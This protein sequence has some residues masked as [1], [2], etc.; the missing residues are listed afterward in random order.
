[1]LFQPA[2]AETY[3]VRVAG[4]VPYEAD[5]TG[6]TNLYVDPLSGWPWANVGGDWLD[7]NQAQQGSTPWA[8][9]AVNS[10]ALTGNGSTYRYTGVVITA[11]AQFVQTSGKPFALRI[12]TPAAPRKVAGIATPGQ[13]PPQVNVTYGDGTSAVLPCRVVADT[14]GTGLTPQTFLPS[15]ATPVF[16]EFDR[17]TKAVASATLDITFNAHFTAAATAQIMLLSPAGAVSPYTGGAGLAASGGELD[18]G[19]SAVSGILGQHRYQDGS[20]L[21]DWV[22]PGAQTITGEA[23]YDPALWGGAS[24]TSKLPHAGL[25]KWINPP[26]DAGAIELVSSSYTGQGF[27]PVAP[28]LGAIKLRMP[29]L[30]TTDGGTYPA[31]SGAAANMM[32]FLPEP[33]FGVLPEIYVRFY[34]RLGT[35]YAITPTDRR[36][37]TAGGSVKWADMSGKWGI[38]AG[39]TT[40]YGGVSGTSG[41]GFGH[42]NR[43]GWYDVDAGLN[44]PSEGGVTVSSHIIDDYQ[45]NN[46]VGHRYGTQGDAGHMTNPQERWG[47]IGGNGGVLYAGQWYEVETRIKLNTLNM[48]AGTWN[49]DGILQG[50]VDGRLVF[51]KTGMVF[52]TPPLF[53]PAYDALKIRP[54]RDIGIKELWLNWFHGGRTPNTV[55]RTVFYAALAYGTARIGSLKQ[56]PAAVPSWVPAVSSTQINV[57]VHAA[58]GG[59]LTANLRSVWVDYYDPYFA[60]DTISAYSGGVL[61]P[62]FGTHGATLFFGGG[63]SATNDNTVSGLVY[64]TATIRPVRLTNPSPIYGASPSQAFANSRTAFA[65]DG[66]EVDGATGRY[67]VDNQPAAAHTYGALTVRSPAESGAALG[68]LF[69]PFLMAATYNPPSVT[70]AAAAFELALASPTT[71]ASNAWTM[72]AVHPTYP[73]GTGLDTYIGPAAYT[74]RDPIRNRTHYAS[75]GSNA[76]VNKP[77]WFD[78]T[79]N[80][81]V[82]G[83]GAQRQA[84][85]A[86]SDTGANVA[87]ESRKL[88]LLLDTTAGG[89]LRIQWLPYDAD[90]PGW[91]GPATLSQAVA[92]PAGWTAASWCDDSQRLLVFDTSAGQDQAFE[93]EI[94]TVMT[95][96]WPVTQVA[97]SQA[98]PWIRNSTYG[99]AQYNPAT[100]AITLPVITAAGTDQVYVLRPRGT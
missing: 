25:G 78:H 91:A 22:V 95:N 4:G 90:Q 34:F 18:A 37:I 33:L 56:P 59:V 94:P 81:F 42:A 53:A 98:V 82:V 14:S 62:Y 11:L 29:A 32:I 66:S 39:H 40:T 83:T 85:V 61:N 28:G 97:L 38:T 15:T 20:V 41:G 45:T 69:T 57:A 49:A 68:S 99:K 12:A 87:V 73:S 16:V 1:M 75:R 76:D 92:I 72:R 43:L 50:W 44:G 47:K 26:T 67:K 93:I 100:K 84:I 5:K 77:R 6:P 13:L 55:D 79:T 10:A 89:A 23:Q 58:G 35:P 2:A 21:T 24:N 88:F 19:L 27:Q 54:C 86:G 65:P 36:Q 8:T 80:T 74:W 7:A 51:E 30:A 9:F 3:P 70:R 63:H 64:E 31:D 48:G 96:A 71:P 60:K 17:P 52:R 46:P